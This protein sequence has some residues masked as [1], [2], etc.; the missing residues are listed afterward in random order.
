MHGL[1]DYL[2]P[3]TEGSILIKENLTALRV[4][5]DIL[6]EYEILMPDWEG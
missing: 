5:Y 3:E 4:K 6:D 1:T 2:D